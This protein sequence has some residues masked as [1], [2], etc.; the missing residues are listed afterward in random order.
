MRLTA[1]IFA[2]LKHPPS[3][4][5]RHQTGQCGIDS[6]RFGRNDI[7]ISKISAVTTCVALNHICVTEALD[8]HKDL[9]SLKNSK[10]ANP[11]TPPEGIVALYLSFLSW[12]LTCQHVCSSDDSKSYIFQF[13]L[14]FLIL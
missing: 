6:W 12:L 2:S 8:T 1:Y 14:L 10:L 4:G 7:V 13:L 5:A 3:L 9:Q 11:G